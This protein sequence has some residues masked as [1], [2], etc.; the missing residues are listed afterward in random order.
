MYKMGQIKECQPY[1]AT[2]FAGAPLQ[3]LL[4]TN[5]QQLCLW[6]VITANPNEG[7]SLNRLCL[8]AAPL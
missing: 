5:M 3:L 7:D 1:I 4:T 2:E 8:L 6:P